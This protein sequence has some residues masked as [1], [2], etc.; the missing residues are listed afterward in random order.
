MRMDLHLKGWLIA[1]VAAGPYVVEVLGQV[2]LLTRVMR[3]LP[4]KVREGLPAHPRRA[5][6]AVFGS[7][8]FFLALFRY[9][10]RNDSDDGPEME[11][12]KRRMRASALREGTFAL[13]FA[14]T[15]SLLWRRGWRPF[16]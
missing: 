8:R 4:G 13:L 3:A 2:P 15:V 14:A 10:L 5:G 9:A 12:L 1:T 11:M 7:A 6:L 16:G